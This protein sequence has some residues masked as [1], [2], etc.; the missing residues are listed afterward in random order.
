VSHVPSLATLPP[1]GRALLD[2]ALRAAELIVW[3]LDF[4]T[5]SIRGAPALFSLL[6][7]DGRTQV[8]L[9]QF[10]RH[11]FDDDRA[12]W[13][14]ALEGSREGAPLD[15]ELRIRGRDGRINWLAL[16]AQPPDDADEEP[17]H[18]VGVLRDIDAQKSTESF[19]RERESQFQAMFEVTSVGMAQ[20]DPFTG[21][22]L[23]INDRLCSMLGFPREEIIG[24]RLLSLMHPDDRETSWASYR[25]LVRGEVS[26]LDLEHR[27]LRRGGGIV[28]VMMTVNLI[29]DGH[30]QPLRTA[31][32]L[33]DIT[34][35]KRVEHSL[36]EREQELREASRVLEERVAERTTELAE[37]N[38][39]LQIE[40][41]ERRQAE[42]RVRELLARQAQAVEEER[43]RISRELHD[44]LGQ[45]L[46]VLAMGLQAMEGGGPAAEATRIAELRR[47]TREI[48][49]DIDRLSHE[50]RPPAL[51]DLGLVEALRSYVLEWGRESG[52]EV[53]LHAHGLH[54]VRFTPLLENTVYRVVQEALTNVRKHAQARR[55]GLVMERRG[56]ELRVVIEDDGCGFEPGQVVSER[57]RHLG[58]RGMEERAHLVG[59]RLE[60]ESRPGH[61]TTL[62]LVI[63][64]EG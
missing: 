9:R 50:L 60:I 53:D 36:R 23:R 22:L 64:L 41:T 35:R 19:V 46:V 12:L 48:E 49:D 2:L 21:R 39:A 54:S 24:H 5:Q 26:T 55:I 28:W 44:S 34:E 62:Y 40:I 38:E 1:R 63:P 25:M 13:R 6:G 57:G 47:V 43:Q 20:A 8:T 61:G 37:A 17:G 10:E 33:M 29:R 31:A 3:E 4:S 59:G 56:L 15:V 42:A 52:V 11:V 51:D 14:S 45:R 16:L 30:G 27:M 58:L 32:V 7:L 18:L